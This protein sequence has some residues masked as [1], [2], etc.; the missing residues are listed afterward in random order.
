MVKGNILLLTHWSFKD[1]LVQAYTLPYLDI[2]RSVLPKQY[3]I[4]IVTSEQGKLALS[5]K[6]IKDVNEQWKQKNIE[7]IAMGYERFGFK[8]L[9]SMPG[10][11]LQLVQLIRRNK[12]KLI[13]SF[14][15]PAGSIAYLLSKVTGTPIIADSYEPHA[16]A[17]VENGTW[18]P[19]GLAYKI[20]STLEKGLTKKAS[21]FIGTTAAMQEYAQTRYGIEIKNLFVKPACV[22]FEK[23]Y[24]QQKDAE[25]LRRYGL[26]DKIVCVY[27]G[28][29]GGIYL[30]KEV[31]DF[32]KCCYEHWG[33]N[34]RFLMVT[35]A[36]REEIDA[37]IE[38]IGVP[39]EVVI[40]KFCL[41]HQVS[42]HL[43]LGDF[44][45]NPVKPGPSRRYCTSIK[46][47]EYWATGLPVVI[48]KDISD[49]SGIIKE[50]NIGAVLNE[51]N[52]TEYKKAVLKIE[53]LLQEPREQLQARVFEVAKRYRDYSIAENIYHIIYGEEK[54]E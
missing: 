37:E 45:I 18:Q 39:Q 2:I 13:H 52:E 47:G 15:T 54:Y 50:N 7:L 29:L 12:I 11:L 8:K 51:L 1:A 43:S 48:T 9:V 36:P 10:Q 35:N 25:L 49:D 32:I 33:D 4:F 22:D 17:M 41:H 42:K 19:N 24:P 20:L 40:S 53:A 26:Q 5:Q 44:G 16:E 6:E 34:F 30:K 3:K 23:F 46:D 21:C 31:F 14:C 28:K 27:A 38:R